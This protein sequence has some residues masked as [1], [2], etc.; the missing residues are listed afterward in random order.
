MS[1]E[2]ADLLATLEAQK[3]LDDSDLD[4]IFAIVMDGAAPIEQIKP[5]LLATVP[6][7]NDPHALAAG[8]RA[9]RERMV[10]VSAPEGAIDVCGTGGDGAHTLNIST[11]VAFVVA[12]CGVPVAKHGNRAMSSK[13]GA[14]DVL[15]ALGVKLTAD[16]P[17][18]ERCLREAG[19]AFLFA[20]N[21]HPAMRHVG[22][23][24]REIGQ[25]T[26]FNL[27]GP[28][29]N[30][31]GVKRQ[32]V[33]V[34]APDFVSPMAE[35]LKLLGAERASVVH[36]AGGLDELSLA[37]EA[38]ALASQPENLVATLANGAITTAYVGASEAGVTVLIDGAA[39]RGGAAGENAAALCDLLNGKTHNSAYE[40][41]V[42]LNA[43][44][45]LMVAGTART[46]AEGFEMAKDA[47]RAGRA[48]QA[49]DALI[50]ITNS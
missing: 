30:P 32:L 2:F 47:L 21:H 50:A 36:G 5:F 19:V 27:L 43:G 46:L 38:G 7:M 31:A 6:L 48:K 44:A 20:Q 8:A 37:S 40:S 23:A 25:R 34:F 13:S 26:I 29:S 16:V 35:A 3:H 1:A 4:R 45:A 42:N 10:R 39:L 14:A 41:I 49:L 33:G 15:E 28:L 11:A 12:G 24:R 17:T 9:L 18:L 22:P